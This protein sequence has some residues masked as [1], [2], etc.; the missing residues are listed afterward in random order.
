M[1]SS[2]VAVLGSVEEAEKEAVLQEVAESEEGRNRLRGKIY[3]CV[4][5]YH[6]WH[7]IIINFSFFKF[8]ILHCQ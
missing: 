2:Y 6:I 4:Y 5:M 8:T 7:N 1:L 3:L